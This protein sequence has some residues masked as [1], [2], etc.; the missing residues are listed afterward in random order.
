MTNEE[1]ITERYDTYRKC[2]STEDGKWVM[3][4]LEQQFLFTTNEQTRNAG[5]NNPIG[6][7]FMAGQQAFITKLRMFAL[8]DPPQFETDTQEDLF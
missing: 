5:D 4:D 7:A 8:T 6:I 3:A 1:Q 2:F